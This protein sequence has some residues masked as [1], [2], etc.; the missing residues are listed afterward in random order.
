M[1]RL[2]LRSGRD[3]RF[4]ARIVETG[5]TPFVLDWGDARF[6]DDA[7]QRLAHG[8]TMWQHGRLVTAHPSDADFLMLLAEL[9]CSEGLLVELDEPTWPGRTESLAPQA[10]GASVVAPV[11]EEL[12]DDPTT[13][14]VNRT[15]SASGDGA[16]P[17]GEVTRS[18]RARP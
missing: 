9:Y 17:S 16:H 10:G 7:Q 8:F 11:Y 13:E 3:A 12:A 6:I 15:G 14:I 5:T 1:L 2:T 18:I 4:L